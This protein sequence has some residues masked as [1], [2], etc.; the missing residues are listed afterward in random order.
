MKAFTTYY[1]DV[2]KKQYVNFAG[3]ATRTNYWMFV[4]FNFLVFLVLSVILSF[5]GD[6]GNVIYFLLTL[7]VLLPS[8]GIAV[9]RLHDTDRSGWWLCSSPSFRL[10]ARWFCWSFWFC[11]APKAPTASAIKFYRTAR[12]DGRYFFVLLGEES[13]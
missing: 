7:A 5:F 2:L 13:V 4:L 9:R 8:L 10:S 1:W 11:P 12:T 3:R 6:V